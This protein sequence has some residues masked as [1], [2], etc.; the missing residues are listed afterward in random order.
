MRSSF[1]P[2][3]TVRYVSLTLRKS[4]RRDAFAARIEM[5]TIVDPMPYDRPADLFGA[6]LKPKGMPLAPLLAGARARGVADGL[7][8]LGLAAVLLDDRGEVLHVNSGAVEL[9]GEDLFLQGGRLRARDEGVDA[10][11]AAAIDCTLS[12]GVASRLAIP[13]GSGRGELGARIGAI[14]SM[15]DDPFQLLRAVAILE[16]PSG[17]AFTQGAPRRH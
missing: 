3:I 15:D 4:R 6:P 16:R 1:G 11:L 2:E 7:E 12:R 17:N 13:L 10:E 5:K 14:D 8:W 9:M